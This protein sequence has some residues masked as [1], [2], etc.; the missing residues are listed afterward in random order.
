MGFMSEKFGVEKQMGMMGSLP[1][2]GMGKEGYI[3][4]EHGEDLRLYIEACSKFLEV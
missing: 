2:V 1:I 4:R 3:P